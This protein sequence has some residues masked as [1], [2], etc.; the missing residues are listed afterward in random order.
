M[1]ASVLDEVQNDNYDPLFSKLNTMAKQGQ[2]SK[3]DKILAIRLCLLV[4]FASKGVEIPKGFQA[5]YF[6]TQY[7]IHIVAA[8]VAAIVTIFASFLLTLLLPSLL[9]A[10]T[11][12]G[13]RIINVVNRS[14]AAASAPS[15]SSAFYD[16]LTSDKTPPP[17]STSL[18]EGIRSLR[19]VILIRHLQRILDALPAAQIPK[20]DSDSSAI[21]IVPACSSL[22][23]AQNPPS[24]RS[25]RYCTFKSVTESPKEVLKPGA[26]YAECAMMRLKV[27]SA[28]SEGDKD[29]KR[30]DKEKRKEKAAEKELQTMDLPDD[31]EFDGELAG[32]RVWEAFEAALKK[33]GRNPTRHRKNWKEKRKQLPNKK[34]LNQGRS[35]LHELQSIGWVIPGEASRSKIQVDATRNYSRP[36]IYL[37]FNESALSVYPKLNVPDGSSIIHSFLGLPPGGNAF[38]M[39][40]FKVMS[41][42]LFRN[43]AEETL[44]QVSEIRKLQLKRIV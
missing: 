6:P 39:I 8:I 10:P 17:N 16:S 37:V 2:A 26:L 30:N 24:L 40:F 41:A 32:R 20:T 42:Q 38:V 36:V 9:T 13:I 3:S 44:I 18:T 12:H 35:P 21:P 23:L 28:P 19:T 11:K 7:A 29:G 15:F 1:I 27:L 33:L 25:S 22:A 31:G 14:Y 34:S 4:Y 43:V 5:A